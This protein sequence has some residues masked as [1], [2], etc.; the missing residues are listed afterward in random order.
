MTRCLGRE[1][2]SDLTRLAVGHLWCGEFGMDGILVL[3]I[4]RG[5]GGDEVS[6]RA[7]SWGGAGDRH[8]DLLSV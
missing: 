8:S 5:D 3:Q 2:K 7:I 6:G 4:L 1:R